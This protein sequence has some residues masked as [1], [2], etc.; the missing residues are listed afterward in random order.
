MYVITLPATQK[1]WC[2]LNFVRTLPVTKQVRHTFNFAVKTVDSNFSSSN[3]SLKVSKHIIGAKIP[4][5]VN[6]FISQPNSTSTHVRSDKVIGWTTHPHYN[7]P[8]QRNLRSLY[9]QPWKLN[10][11][12]ILR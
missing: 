7:T 6:Y 4:R 5:R 11:V 12:D 8:P 2:T 10:L 3:Y 1:M 9:I